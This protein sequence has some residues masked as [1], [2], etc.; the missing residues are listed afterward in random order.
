MTDT[1]HCRHP[2]LRRLTLAATLVLVCLPA[3]ALDPSAATEALLAS[4]PVEQRAI[5]DGYVN[6]G[7]R[8]SVAAVLFDLLLAYLILRSGWSRRWRDLAERRASRSYPQALV[9]VP[10]YLLVA[11]I[12]S[13]PLAW[14]ADFVIEH[15]YGL[16]NQNFGE[17]FSE[18]LLS[19]GILIA[20][21]TLFLPLLYF[22]VRRSP[23]RWWLWGSGLT[24]TCF[25]LLLLVAP[26]VISPLFNDFR[27]MDEGALK[28]RIIA[29]AHANG[30]QADDVMQVDQSKQTTRVSANVSGLFGTTRISLNDNLLA[31]ASEDGVEAVMAHEIG[32]YVLHHQYDR[33]AWYA[34]LTMLVFSLVNM[35]FGVL[36]RF[37][38]GSWG[39]RHV[40][41]YAGLPLL[42]ALFSL[43]LFLLTPLL[44]KITY[45]AE[46]EA[47]LFALNATRNPDAWAEVALLTADY[48]KLRPPAWE[49]ALLNHHPSP[50]TRIYTSM[51]W[52]EATM[53][54]AE[55][56]PAPV[57]H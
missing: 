23:E 51:R 3:A 32:H 7:Y 42:Y 45:V 13:L 56:P 52:K 29:I 1:P 40:G 35:S 53:P 55:Q 2:V 46:A 9:Y 24:M 49:E 47:D 11:S 36:M 50:F 22:I 12:L 15:R 28:D 17:W 10:I 48:R 5:S 8:I 30:L 37:R 54:S 26:V 38:G 41:D 25:A 6:A 57:L 43:Y 39:I 33:L 21:L 44:H 16:S 27:P 4:V 31:R 19:T 14:Y 34:L 18:H 20:G